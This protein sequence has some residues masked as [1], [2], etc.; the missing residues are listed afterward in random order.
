M[1][2]IALRSVRA[3]RL[4]FVLC[5]VAVLL[6]IAFVG[7]AMVFTDTLSTALKEKFAG[8]TADIAV[9]P[10]SQV[11]AGNGRPAT[12]TSDLVNRITQVPGVAS[13]DPQLLVSDVQIL[14]PEGKPTE[15]YGLPT[16]GGA[17]LRDPQAAPFAMLD[18]KPPW[19]GAELALDQST[20]TREGYDLGDE[21]KVVTATTA[22][23]AK[24]TAI[25]TPVRS[26]AAAGSPLVTFDAATAQRLLLGKPGWTS[27]SVALKAGSDPDTVTKAIA[28]AA[29]DNVRVR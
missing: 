17:W 29:G 5:T 23:S 11:D 21:V 4:R 16:F 18:G 25:T 28:K 10:V 8:S 19:G 9:T 2:K 27:I 1:L 22:V 13:A 7:G 3:H 24:L 14:G 26:G 15:T 6:G 12:L 20:A